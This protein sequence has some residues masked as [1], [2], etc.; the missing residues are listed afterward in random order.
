MKVKIPV[1]NFVTFDIKTRKDAEDIIDI[2]FWKTKQTNTE[3]E[4]TWWSSNQYYLR[5][6]H[7]E[8]QNRNTRASYVDA[9]NSLFW[10][11]DRTQEELVDIL[12]LALNIKSN[13]KL[14]Q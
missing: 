3:A 10:M 14:V 12:L 4:I 2:L 9:R 5:V 13:A 7:D 11:A 1:T 8:I 6:C